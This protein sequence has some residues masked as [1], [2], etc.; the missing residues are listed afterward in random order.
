MT[1][2]EH[3]R[4]LTDLLNEIAGADLQIQ[5][6]R[7]MEERVLRRWD[8]GATAS[9]TRTAPIRW[10]PRTRGW[11]ISGAGALAAAILLLV[12]VN[13][14]SRGSVA[15]PAKVVHFDVRAQPT[16]PE[17]P[18]APAML[19]AVAPRPIAIAR[20]EPEGGARRV[21]APG[22]IVSFMPLFPD[23]HQDLMGSFQIAR[24]LLPREVLADLGVVLDAN[25][26]G[27]PIQADVV[28]GED[29][30]ARAIRLA[31]QDTGRSQ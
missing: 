21:D 28:F 9:D 20:D 5:V 6:P 14:S 1:D 31:Q 8:A 16:A 7:T 15:V 3:N 4:R 27:E 29:G 17:F 24:V 12:V 10:H 13:R 18:T 2:S 22:E 26:V 30:L 25:R 11:L 19:P 23:A